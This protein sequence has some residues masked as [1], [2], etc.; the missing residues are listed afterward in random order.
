MRAK[1]R[2]WFNMELP[3]EAF[4]P[5]VSVITLKMFFI[6]FL[7]SCCQGNIFFQQNH[8]TYSSKLW[9]RKWSQADKDYW[10]KCVTKL[11]LLSVTKD[12]DASIRVNMHQTLFHF[13]LYLPY[14]CWV[15][16]IYLICLVFRKPFWCIIWIFCAPTTLT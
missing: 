3:I 4:L 14:I 10:R 7:I 16:M 6:Y 11:Y 2:G 12:K 8:K 5:I 15:D 13:H 9:L 1:C